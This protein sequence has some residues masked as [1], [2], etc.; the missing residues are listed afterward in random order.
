MIQNSDNMKC[1]KLREGENFMVGDVL[2]QDLTKEDVKPGGVFIIHLLMEEQCAMPDKAL[3]QTILD[4]YLNH[5]NCFGYSEETACFE[6]S[7]YRVSFENDKIT[8]HPQL[9]IT[10]CSKIQMPIMDDVAKTQLW[11]CPNG[12]E[13]LERCHYQVLA[14]DMLASVLDYRE[15]AQ[16]LVGYIEALAELYPT[17]KAV[18]FENSKK[19]L[20][21]EAILH[22]ELP[23]EERFLYYGV[24]IRFF[25]IQGTNDMLVDSLGMSTLFLPDVQYHFH[26]LNPNDIVNHAYDMLYYIYDYNNPIESG[27]TITGL[28]DGNPDKDVKWKLQYEQS[29]IQPV[30]EVIDVNTLAFAAGNRE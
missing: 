25:N 18:V 6:A 23:K 5:V 29:L 7:D 1:F 3:F 17:C 22:C 19:R 11:N 15:R 20:T 4:K 8:A 12:E 26:G 28:S 9:M 24:N 27:N 21:R 13:I 10:S 16:L 2:A 14:T 30:R